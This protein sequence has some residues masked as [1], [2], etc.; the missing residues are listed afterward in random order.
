MAGEWGFDWCAV[1][2]RLKLH[3]LWTA[4]IEEKLAICEREMI[5]LTVEL[6]ERKKANREKPA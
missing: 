1:A 6:D 3:G 4:E 5:L 2:E